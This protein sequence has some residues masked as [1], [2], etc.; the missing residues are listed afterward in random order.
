MITDDLKFEGKRIKYLLQNSTFKK[1]F[2]NCSNVTRDNEVFIK[3][4]ICGKIEKIKISTLISKIDKDGTY[5]PI[6]ASCRM[7]KSKY[8]DNYENSLSFVK[9]RPDIF[10]Q[11]VWKDPDKPDIRNATV[12][13]KCS[14]GNIKKIEARKFIKEKMY[15]PSFKYVCPDCNFKNILREA[16]TYEDPLIPLNEDGTYNISEELRNFLSFK[17]PTI[18]WLKLHTAL[19][20]VREV[21]SLIKEDLPFSFKLNLIRSNK[22]VKYCPICGKICKN[23]GKSHFRDTCGDFNCVRELTARTCMELYGGKS[24]YAS[25]KVKEK[26]KKTCKEKY[27]VENIFEDADY[28]KECTLKKLGVTNVFQKTEYISQCVQNKYGVTNSTYIKCGAESEKILRDKPLFTDVVNKYKCDDGTVVFKEIA[29]F[30]KVSEGCI[31]SKFKEFGLDFYFKQNRSSYEYSLL[32]YLH[33]FG[34]NNEDI[35]VGARKLIEGNPLLEVDLYIPSRNIG[36]EINGCKWHSTLYKEKLYHQNKALK[37]KNN[38][39]IINIYEFEWLSL[40]YRN[41][42]LALLRDLLVGPNEILKVGDTTLREIN[43]EI[44]DTFLDE[45]N[46]KWSSNSDIN[47]GLYIRDTLLEVMS[48]S[49]IKDTEYTLDRICRLPYID[50]KVINIYLVILLISIILKS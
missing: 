49:K 42:N 4:K 9:S 44:A 31:K 47:L 11:I 37:A 16:S 38:L 25:D 21:N 27:D 1:E 28:I 30:L 17:T 3:C 50:K 19:P 40:G 5:E 46:L 29:D 43:K 15:E 8:N 34:V 13:L 20:I 23:D 2:E 48:F 41:K 39:R 12:E 24:P 45:Y 10:N 6:C 26:G 33:G 18:K 35:I 7:S 22:K 32:K 14:C 36:I